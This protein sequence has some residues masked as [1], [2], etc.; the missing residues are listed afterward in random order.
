LFS[1]AQL[2][3]SDGLF[4]RESLRTN[5]SLQ[6]S[7]LFFDLGLVNI[8]EQWVYEAV[9]LKG[10]TAW[11]LQRLVIINLLKEKNGIAAKYLK[12]LRRTLW[13]RK[14]A[15]EYQKYLSD[16]SG[17]WE[18]P[19]YQRIKN[20]MPESDF[21][22]SPT[23]PSLCLEELLKDKKNKMAFE[24]FM[25]HCLLEGKIGIFTENVHR[26]NSF[27]YPKTP[28]HFEEAILVCKQIAAGKGITLPEIKI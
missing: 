22:V 5:F 23:E 20:I 24:Y 13:H 7:D 4:M 19:L 15:T 26:M 21:L 17:F 2:F 28:R 3:G 25:A 16:S 1:V 9:S 18:K 12:M 8:S 6:H 27:D 14:W 11:N 10:D